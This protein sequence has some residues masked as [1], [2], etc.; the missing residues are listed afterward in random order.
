MKNRIARHAK[1]IAFV[2]TYAFEVAGMA[3][4]AIGAGM[5]YR[6]LGFIVGG[7]LAIAI[8]EVKA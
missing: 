3:S 1:V 5:I 4:V 8:V 7:A 2:A 6:P